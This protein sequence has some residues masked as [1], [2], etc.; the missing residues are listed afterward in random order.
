MLSQELETV[1]L[2]VTERVAWIV[3]NRPEALNA[4]TTTLGADIRTALEHAAEDPEIRA[5]VLTGAGRAFSS[6]ADLKAGHALNAEGKPDVRTPLREVYNPLINLVRTIP[7]PVI[8]AVNGPAVGIGC[9]LAL[10]CDLIVA[11]ESAYFLLAFVNIGLGLDGGAS[12]TLPARVGHARAFEIA[13][14]GERIGAAQ[15]LEWGLV[16]R[17]VP[18]GELRSAV[19]GFAAKLAAGPPG[20]YAAIKRTINDRLYDGFEQL[21]ELEA[22]V[23]QQRA[24]SPDFV[25]G[26]LSFMQKRPPQF[27][28]E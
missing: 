21:L 10:A 18:D 3:L 14:L 24:S 5:I 19:D 11:A 7:K 4:W 9:S 27:T 28:G 6:G 22:E 23:Q 16:N 20:S 12:Q 8:A 17:V 25:E 15:A 26:V 2:N 1:E 13:Y